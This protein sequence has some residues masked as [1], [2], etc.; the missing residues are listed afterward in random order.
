MSHVTTLPRSTRLGK[1]IFGNRTQLG[2]SLRALAGGAGMSV[3]QVHNL[4]TGKDTNP[5]LNTMINLSACL[6]VSVVVMVRAAIR[7]ID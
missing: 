7:E 6:G 4:E 5:T 2:L 1:F 3:S